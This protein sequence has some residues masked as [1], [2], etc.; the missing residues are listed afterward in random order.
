MD[1]KL[2]RE[3]ISSLGWLRGLVVLWRT[4]IWCSEDLSA[5]R[6]IEIAFNDI[7]NLTL[8][9]FIG[10]L[11]SILRAQEAFGHSHAHKFNGARASIN[12][13]RSCSGRIIEAT[14]SAI[15]GFISFATIG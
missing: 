4:A 7:F 3:R 6:F 13:T 10:F 14:L 8:V 1:Y 15:M 2:I 12:G 9:H 11:L 5:R